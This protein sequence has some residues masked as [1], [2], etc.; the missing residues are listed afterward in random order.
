MTGFSQTFGSITIYDGKEKTTCAELLQNIKEG[1]F[2]TGYHFRS[3]LIHRSSHKVADIVQSLPDD[4]S[5]DRIIEEIMCCFSGIPSTT[6]A[7]EALSHMKQQPRQNFWIY[8]NKWKDL[9]WWCT[10]IT[11]QEIFVKFS[12]IYSIVYNT[13]IIVHIL[14]FYLV[15]Q[16]KIKR[17]CWYH[18]FLSKIR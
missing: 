7:I 5:H 9:H 14:S 1:S 10:V 3:A 17:L 11:V 16:P 12:T 8:I 18:L 2:Q 15:L 6:A 13:S 4:L